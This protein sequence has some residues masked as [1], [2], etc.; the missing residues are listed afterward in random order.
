VEKNIRGAFVDLFDP[1]LIPEIESGIINFQNLPEEE[2]R[3]IMES[4]TYSNC[5]CHLQED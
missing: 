4:N 3:K 1:S 5:N 2:Q